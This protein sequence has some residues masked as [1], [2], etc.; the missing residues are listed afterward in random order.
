VGC[1]DDAT[2]AVRDLVAAP[3][4]RCDVLGHDRWGRVLTVCFAAGVE[5]NREMV[6]SGWALAYYPERGAI[7]GPAYDAEQLEA[8][9]AQRGLWEGSFVPPWVWRSR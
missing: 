5:L 2:A 4:F 1:G 8:K 3:R 9:H 7:P 6:P